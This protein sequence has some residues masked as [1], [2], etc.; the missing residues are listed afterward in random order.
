[1]GFLGRLAA[2]PKLS[3]AA[4]ARAGGAWG[5][6]RVGSALP[7]WAATLSRLPPGGRAASSRAPGEY[8]QVFRCSVAEPEK[9]WGAVAEQIQWYKPWARA[10]DTGR[11]G[12]ASW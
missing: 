6:P 8:D 2:L 3:G 12:S 7:G 10:L 5:R 1:M 11:P 4:A 9:L